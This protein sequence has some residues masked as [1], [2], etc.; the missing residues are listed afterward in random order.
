MD[1]IMDND[2][3]D[4]DIEITQWTEE[5]EMDFTYQYEPSALT[6]DGSGYTIS[7]GPMPSVVPPKQK[8]MFRHYI[9]SVYYY[10]GN[11]SDEDPEHQIESYISNNPYLQTIKNSGQLEFSMDGNTIEYWFIGTPQEHLVWRMTWSEYLDEICYKL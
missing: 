11:V 3:F 1:K 5:N 8:D 4:G 9:Q 7:F 10:D 6:L 2:I